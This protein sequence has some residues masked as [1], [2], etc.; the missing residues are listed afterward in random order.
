[1][2]II[3]VAE[4]AA[5]AARLR[6]ATAMP[7]SIF[8]DAMAI[9]KGVAEHGDSAVLDYTAKFDGTKLDSLLAS[10]QEIKQAYGQVT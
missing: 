4:P 2:K 8:V 7:E 9:M 5:D 6:R 10:R 3:N 1:M